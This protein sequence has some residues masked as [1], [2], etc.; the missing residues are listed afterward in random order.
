MFVNAFPKGEL[1][2][3]ISHG[4]L[5]I[6]QKDKLG[7]FT[8]LNVFLTLEQIVNLGKMIHDKGRT[9]LAE[10]LW[11]DKYGFRDDHGQ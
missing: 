3:D 6:W 5:R 1:Q 11:E 7:E 10:K 9:K 8:E 4:L 2:V